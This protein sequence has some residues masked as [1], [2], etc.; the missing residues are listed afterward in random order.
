MSRRSKGPRLHFRSG[1]I[2]SRTGKPI[3]DIYY[4]RDG[5][6][7]ISTGCGP[8]GLHGPEGAEA[9]LAAYIT[10]KW[11]TRAAPEEAVDDRQRRS[12]P[13]QVLIAE[14]L[15]LYLAEKAPTLARPK[16]ADSRIRTLLPFWEA[17]MLC[18][19]RRSECQAYVA[20]RTSQTIKSARHGAA[21]DKKVTDQAARRELEDLSAAIGYWNGEY[22]LT[23]RPKV[24]MPEKA[25][26]P[27]DALT[28][29]QAARLLMAARGYRWEL[30]AAGAKAGQMGWTRLGSSARANRAH[31]KRFVLMGLYTGTR[32]GVIPKVLWSESP[33]QAWADLHTGQ[34]YRRGKR[35]K[36]HKTKRRP[37][38]NL[39]PRLLAHMRRWRIQDLKL[40]KRLLEAEGLVLANTVLHHGGAPIGG[41]IRTG[42]ENCVAD[43]GLDGEI[44]PH[45]MRHTCATWLM[46]ADVKVWEAAGY[47]GMTAKML[48]DNYGHHRPSHQASARRALG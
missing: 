10:E 41:R 32:P 35:E 19:V 14:I 47:V 16:D 6:V 44:S 27:R 34:I 30:Q 31:L 1:R 5:Q 24:W 43:A 48:E 45:W 42:F 12:D 9:Q 22:P 15:A 33:V 25:E 38:V 17:K 23:N 40:A 18:D 20:L 37:I 7:E 2:H 11:A 26:G 36:D 13:A 21:L 29:A 28:R 4:I 8:D 3:P 39:S 46:E